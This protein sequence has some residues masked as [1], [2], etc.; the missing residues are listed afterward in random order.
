MV[1]KVGTKTT[2]IE[3]VGTVLHRE[4]LLKKLL[5][6]PAYQ[7][8][9]YKS[10]VSWSERED[11]WDKWR[12]IY[13]DLDNDSRK[14]ESQAFYDQNQAEMLRGTKVLWPEYEDY[15]YLMQEMVEIGKRAFMKE[16]QNE[17]LG[18]E[19]KVFEKFHFYREIDGGIQIE[20]S[21]ATFTWDELHH[22]YGT[23]DPATGQTKAKKGKL[24]DFSCLL[25][26]YHDP[27]GRLLVHCDW[28]KRAPPSRYIKEVF[29]HHER[30]DYTKFG[31]ETNLYRN[32][33]LPNIIDERNRREKLKKKK[34]KIPFYDIENIDNKEKRIY[35]LEPKVNHGWI[36]F[37]R[38][39]SQEFMN[40]L[41]EFPHADHDDCP[42]ALEMLWALVHN[43]FKPAPI[44]MSPMGTR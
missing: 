20:S 17:P 28:T 43:R 11:L 8:K 23:L 38:A 12:Q 22:A 9:T 2:N 13:T 30:F 35:A 34:I 33:L 37:N 19:D 3:V 31:V 39:L 16:K 6:N 44:S 27:K 4:S 42:D 14:E 40:Q 25:S 18:A 26:G 29:E 21:G 32:L 1:S 5:K 41:E 36:I 15:L 7:G 24:G 10:I